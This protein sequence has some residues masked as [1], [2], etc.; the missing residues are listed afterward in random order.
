M[1]SGRDS[2]SRLHEKCS[3]VHYG[4]HVCMHAHCHDGLAGLS[5]HAYAGFDLYT[6]YY[7]QRTWAVFHK[8]PRYAGSA[9]AQLGIGNARVPDVH[10]WAVPYILHKLQE[11]AQAG[12]ERL[13]ECLKCTSRRSALVSS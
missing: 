1:T 7:R 3:F 5:G 13:Q 12:L 8:E 9:R 6:I 2:R 11:Y 4:V 10:A